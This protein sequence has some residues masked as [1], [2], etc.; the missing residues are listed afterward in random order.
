MAFGGWLGDRVYHDVISPVVVADS[1]VVRGI[2]NTSAGLVGGDKNWF[3]RTAERVGHEADTN[4]ESPNKAVWKAGATV[5]AIYTGGAAVDW[6]EG[7][8]AVDAAAAIDTAT[9]AETSVAADTAVTTEYGYIGTGSSAATGGGEIA[10]QSAYAA[11][12]ESLFSA[13]PAV[14]WASTLT[15]GLKAYNAVK[16]ATASQTSAKAM[17]AGVLG[18]PA[19]AQTKPVGAQAVTGTSS[20]VIVGAVIVVALLIM[21]HKAA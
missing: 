17:Q 5:A 19:T 6:Y 2:A 15:Q 20:I 12:T 11:G 18:L 16:A 10:A 13:A 21:K 14:D 4:I 8:T 9:V 1:R 7:A 3:G